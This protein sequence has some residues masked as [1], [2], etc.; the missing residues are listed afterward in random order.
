VAELIHAALPLPVARWIAKVEESGLARFGLETPV[1]T[2]LIET[3]NHARTQI[4]VGAP[5]DAD[6]RYAMVVGEPYVGI[7]RNEALEKL[8]GACA[9]FR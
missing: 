4:R 1:Y 7:I 6:G 5:A 2:W 9:A 8:L 3:D